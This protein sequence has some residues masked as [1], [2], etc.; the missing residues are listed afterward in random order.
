VQEVQLIDVHVS[1]F[2][3]G[4]QSNEVPMLQSLSKIKPCV[5]HLCHL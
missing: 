4:I 3:P 1:D 2:D 5:M